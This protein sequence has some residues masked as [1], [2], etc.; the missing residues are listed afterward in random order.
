MQSLILIVIHIL[1][2]ISTIKISYKLKF[3]DVPDKR[4][5]HKNK[6][7]HTGGIAIFFTYIIIL[8]NYEL[9][10]EI[11][12]LVAVGSILVIFGFIDDQYKL[13]P[14]M[15]LFF[16]FLPIIYLISEGLYLEDLGEYKSIGRIEL[17]KFA[18]IFTLLSVAL[19]VNS[20]NYLDGIDGLCLIIAISSLIYFSIITN[21]EN[22]NQL[23][24]FLSI[25]LFINLFFNLLPYKTNYK[26]FLGNSGSLFFGFFLSF[27][28]IY[29]YKFEEISP[30]KLIWPVWLPVFDFLYVNYSRIINNK[31][32]FKPSR[33]H[34]HHVT[35]EYFKNN[36]YALLFILTINT[37]IIFLGFAICKFFDNIY[38]L[39][40]FIILFVVYFILRRNFKIK[41]MR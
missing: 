32:I 4:K 12:N 8:A 39:A 11:E 37:I 9:N 13:T 6:I 3:F 18:I 21:N 25:P 35:L 2:L 41:K 17:N 29:L 1:I 23:L 22:T 36:L 38:A 34:I 27:L 20:I 16:I 15:K 7:I 14:G 19:L 10:T 26:I 40:F 31:S 28:M 30:A 5:I 24:I 33:D